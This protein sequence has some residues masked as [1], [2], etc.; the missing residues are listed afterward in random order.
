MPSVPPLGPPPRRRREGESPRR[1]GGDRH[2]RRGHPL[3][4][5]GHEGWHDDALLRARLPRG[6]QARRQEPF[7]RQG[8]SE[9]EDGVPPRTGSEPL[10]LRRREDEG[11]RILAA[12]S[13]RRR[14]G[15]R[16]RGG[17]RQALRAH[18]RQQHP[19]RRPRRGRLQRRPVQPRRIHPPLG[20]HDAHP[21]GLCRPRR[22]RQVRGRLCG[23]D[24][25]SALRV[26]EAHV[27]DP[28]PHVRR[29]RGAGVPGVRVGDGVVGRGRRRGRESG[30]P[31]GGRRD[32]EGAGGE[33]GRSCARTR[34]RRRGG[35]SDGAGD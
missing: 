2:G 33:G 7:G 30:D 17:P 19:R 27:D 16:D 35:D 13:R 1:K 25:S 4:A 20:P 8:E 15:S 3:L 21:R 12:P 5:D 26:V 9:E 24:R 10:W 11:G 6:V 31:E 34:A 32:P 29:G 23:T 28:I 18:S 14:P 22:R